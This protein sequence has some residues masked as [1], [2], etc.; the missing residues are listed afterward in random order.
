[1]DNLQPSPKE[2]IISKD[3]MDTVQRLNDSGS[4]SLGCCC[5]KGLRYSPSHIESVIPNR[6]KEYNNSSRRVRKN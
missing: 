6:A 2:S 3:S 1:M 5:E 4:F